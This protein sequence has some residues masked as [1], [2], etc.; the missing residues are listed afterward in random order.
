[1]PDDL[2]PFADALRLLTPQPPAMS[3]DALLFA[4]G[5]AAG[6][7]RPWLWPTAAGAFASLSAVLAGFVVSPAAPE[8]RYVELERIVYVERP[9]PDRTETAEPSPPASSHSVA[10]EDESRERLRLL[11][12]RRDVLRWG[13]EM[14][15]ESKPSAGPSPDVVA[16][17]LT[18]WL[19]LP[20]GTFALPSQTKTSAPE[21]EEDK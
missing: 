20:A 12:V 13:V 15:P 6:R 10:A 16:R 21:G 8:V 5:K 19:N 11:Q 14:L 9:A 1:M 2:T 4:A 17:D 18:N 3:R 7:P